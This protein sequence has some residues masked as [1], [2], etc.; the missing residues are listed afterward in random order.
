[1]AQHPLAGQGL[2]RIG[3]SRSHSDTPHSVG[4]LWT[5]DQ[6]DAETTTCT[7]HSAHKRQ[8]S[9]PP[10]RFDPAVPASKMP[11]THA[12]DRA[13]SGIGR[14]G[15]TVFKRPVFIE[16]ITNTLNRGHIASSDFV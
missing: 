9:M 15:N 16:S 3:V 4:L 2:L 11:K 8:T 13:A 10:V 5:S 14:Y 1:M 12:L 7:T 6:T